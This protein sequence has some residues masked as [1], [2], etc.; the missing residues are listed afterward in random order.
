ML[1]KP[2]HLSDKL[3]NISINVVLQSKNQLLK[4]QNKISITFRK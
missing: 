2:K 4:H 3:K 1:K